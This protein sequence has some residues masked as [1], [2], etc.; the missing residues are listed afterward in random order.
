[1]DN[2]SP[3]FAAI[4]S[5]N[6]YRALLWFN[7]AVQAVLSL[8]KHA[9]QMLVHGVTALNEFTHYSIV[10]LSYYMHECL[11]VTSRDRVCGTYK[12]VWCT[13]AIH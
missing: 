9:Q 13:A 10:S 5:Q 7:D 3:G 1:M 2:L 6:L 4:A 8:S 11:H 12:A